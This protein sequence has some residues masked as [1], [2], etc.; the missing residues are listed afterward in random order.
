MYRKSHNMLMR[1]GIMI[2]TRKDL[3]INQDVIRNVHYNI[4][5]KKEEIHLLSVPI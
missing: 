2:S 5:Q 1:L 3:R 4:V